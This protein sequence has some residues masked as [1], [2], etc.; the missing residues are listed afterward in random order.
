MGILSRIFSPL[1]REEDQELKAAGELYELDK[2]LISVIRRVADLTERCDEMYSSCVKTG[3]W[4]SSS[5]QKLVGMLLE[6]TSL[7]EQDK[8]Y[9][10][11]E[12]KISHTH[13]PHTY[14]KPYIILAK[15]YEKQGHYDKAIATCREAIKKGYTDD[16]TKGGM[17]GRIERLE[18]KQKSAKPTND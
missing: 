14:Y 1:T 6:C 17:R 9:W 11:E 15:V 4:N 10:V 7:S 5:A 16:G 12:G 8:A 13:Y 18:K 2:R 3:A